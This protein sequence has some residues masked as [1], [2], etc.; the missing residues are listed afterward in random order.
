LASAEEATTVIAKV[1]IAF[2]IAITSCCRNSDPQCPRD[3]QQ[4]YGRGESAEAK[5]TEDAV[6]LRANPSAATVACSQYFRLTHSA[7]GR[8][9]ARMLKLN[10]SILAAVASASAFASDPMLALRH[11]LTLPATQPIH[12]QI[13]MGTVSALSEASDTYLQKSEVQ[14]VAPASCGPNG[15]VLATDDPTNMGDF[16]IEVAVTGEPARQRL[17]RAAGANARIQGYRVFFSDAARR[18]APEGALVRPAR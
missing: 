7:S 11:P 3:K 5:A 8:K 14:W 9:T 10:L 17:E 16:C 12:L 2:F 6:R 1:N 4:Y 13:L 15:E 18:Q